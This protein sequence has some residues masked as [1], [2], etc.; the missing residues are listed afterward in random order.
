M[1]NNSQKEKPEKEVTQET[2]VPPVE[3]VLTEEDKKFLKS[4]NISAD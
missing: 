3:L 1:D 2:E 4:C